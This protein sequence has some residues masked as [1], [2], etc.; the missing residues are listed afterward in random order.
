MMT[1]GI[2]NSPRV[3]RTSFPFEGWKVQIR[4]LGD[5]YNRFFSDAEFGSAEIAREAALAFAN[6]DSVSRGKLLGLQ[7]R[8]NCKVNNRSGVVGVARYEGGSRRGPFWVAYITDPAT[9][10]RSSRTFSVSRHGEE[11]ARAQAIAWRQE[12]ARELLKAYKEIVDALRVPI[13]ASLKR[14]AARRLRP[15]TPP[16]LRADQSNVERAQKT[17]V[18]Q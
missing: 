6:E 18:A 3:Y 13:A 10:R 16:S 15:S 9:G 8:F 1:D 12:A 14:R 17:D 4:I 5:R 2:E 11:T 7:R